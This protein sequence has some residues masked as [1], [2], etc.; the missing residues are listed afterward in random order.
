MT[1][2]VFGDLHGYFDLAFRLLRYWQR[3]QG[4]VVD[5]VL[6]VGDFGAFPDP[7]RAERATLGL[8]KRTRPN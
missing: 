2:A 8:R 7:A 3:Q 4:D 1:V 5:A 6:Q